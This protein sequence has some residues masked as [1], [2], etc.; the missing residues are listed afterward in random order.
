MEYVNLRGTGLSVSKACLG[1][2]TF[3]GQLSEPDSIRVIHTAMERG[4]NFIDTADVYCD[5]A[6]EVAVGKALNGRRDS[7]VLATKVGL[8][9]GGG[10]NSRGLSRLHIISGLEASLRRLGTDYV[11][12]YYLH[13]PDPFTPIEEILQTM[14]GLVRSGKIRYIG[15]SNYSAW[16]IADLASTAKEYHFVLPTVTQ[17]VYNLLTR[18]IEAELVPMVQ[19]HS[20]GLIVYNPLMSGLLTGKHH[21]GAAVPGSRLADNDVYRKR[22]WSD[23]N[24]DACE[25]LASI[26]AEAGMRPAELALRWCA[27]QP[28]VNAVLMGVSKLSHLESNLAPLLAP[29]LPGNVSAACDKVWSHMSVGTRYCYYR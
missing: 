1:S 24:L 29:A 8:P 20:M 16:Q 22:Y 21:K 12:L 26:A 11:D 10:A 28:M 6:S 4:I 23:E 7:V 13:Q 18:G 3:G 15:V 2:M 5:G 19:A 17:N 25:E 14:D 9:T 27:N